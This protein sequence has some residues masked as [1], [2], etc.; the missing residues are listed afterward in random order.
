ME[1]PL[2]ELPSFKPLHIQGALH[3]TE[4]FTGLLGEFMVHSEESATPRH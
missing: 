4:K 1:V 2:R 3:S